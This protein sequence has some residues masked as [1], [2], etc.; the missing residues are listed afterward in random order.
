[1]ALLTRSSVMPIADR[2]AFTMSPKPEVG[3][4]PQLRRTCGA[5][6]RA[7]QTRQRSD[8]GSMSQFIR[9]QKQGF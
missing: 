1:M 2:P 4:G 9:K 8:S 6:T 5:E 7:L 3:G